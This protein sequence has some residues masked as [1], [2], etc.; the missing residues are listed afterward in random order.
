MAKKSLISV[1]FFLFVIF[2]L[3]CQTQPHSGPLNPYVIE[4]PNY[5][6]RAVWASR[7]N[8]KT[9]EDVRAIIKN[10]KDYN[11]NVLVFQVRGNGTVFYKSELEPWSEMLGGKDPGWDPLQL[12][13]DE[14]RKAGIELHA[15]IN[16]FP[17]WRGTKPPQWENQLW[18]AHRDWFMIP[19][20]RRGQPPQL[21]SGYSFI[22]PG[23]PEVKQY[24]EQL[25]AE[26]VSKYEIDGLHF[27]YIR[28]PGPEYSYDDASIREFKRRYGKDPEMLPDKWREWRR[29]Q[30]TDVVTRCYRRA[31]SIRPS[32][33]ISAAVFGYYKRAVYDYF[34]DSH[35]WLQRGIMDFTFPMIYRIDPQVFRKYATD[36]VVNSHQRYAF[37]GLGTYLMKDTPE[38]MLEQVAITRELNSGGLI[39]FD[40]A[41]L[42]PEH[43]PG[44]MAQA[45][46]KGPF[47]KPAPLPP[48]KWIAST[49]DD[50]VGPLITDV[51]IN[52]AKILVGGSFTVECTIKDPSGICVS[53]TKSPRLNIRRHKWS[54]SPEVLGESTLK[55]KRRW[56]VLPT[57]RFYTP[58]PISVP[59]DTGKIYLQ[60]FAYDND[61][62]KK[63][64]GKKDIS[65]G[66]SEVMEIP[67]LCLP[68]GYVFQKEIGP[69]IKGAQ[70]AAVDNQGRVWVCS[71]NEDAI[72][73]LQPNGNQTDF[74]PITSSLDDSNNTVEIRR[75]RGIAITPDNIVLVTNSEGNLLL[76]FDANNGKPLQ[77]IKLDFLCGDI[78]VDAQGY[79]YATEIYRRKWHKLTPEGKDTSSHPYSPFSPESVL[80][81]SPNLNR[82]IAVTKDGSRVYVANEGGNRVDVYDRLKQG[83]NESYVFVKDIHIPVGDYTGAVD[84]A[85][86]GSLFVSDGDGMVKVFSPDGTFKTMLWRYDS[87]PGFPRGV[88]FSPDGK[89]LYI[90]QTG[91]FA[92]PA[93]IEQWAVLK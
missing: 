32:I 66:S 39:F 40:Y 81:S 57:D 70:F 47:A 37:P 64:G 63:D 26:L 92:T 7:F 91:K 11:F 34:Q 90:V 25:V 51:K 77:A 20:E 65:V 56:L 4:K 18:N 89:T 44:K 80:F 21:Q 48:M 58:K 8:Y 41:S 9:P 33:K 75:P 76:R 72:Y 82:G 14:C 15:W 23:N 29:E 62:D 73:V 71:W 3:S 86:D 38:P 67:V 59:S 85:P 61:K 93:F 83:D 79:I 88:A 27:D 42:F 2:A 50:V 43:K 74:S 60:I 69:P 30:V 6:L 1:L 12:A 45:L 78:D 5:E 10:L 35:G 84:V 46:L 36:H 55:R 87:Q 68:E 54:L 22:S 49:D 24:L 31:K 53:G 17:A 19:K 16:V 52:P 13:I 28:Y